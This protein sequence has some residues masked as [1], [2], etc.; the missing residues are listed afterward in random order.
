M[1]EASLNVK[2]R[3]KAGKQFSKRLRR[4][5]LIPGVLYGLGMDPMPL[6]IDMKELLS[7][8]HSAGRN[9]V[10]NLAIEDSKKKF[11][12]F[13]YD[14]QHDPISGEIIHIDMKQ[15]SLNEKINVTIPIRL[16]G[17]SIG[18]KTEDGIVEHIM[19]TLDIICLPSDI[20]EEITVDISDLQI[21]DGIHVR[22]LKHENFDILSDGENVAVHIIAPRVVVVAE[23]E[24][25]AE[26]EEEELTEPEV[27]GE[28][29]REEEK[30][31]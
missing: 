12:S 7:L 9:V 23:A 24:E 27:I 30:E 5:K 25:V 4:E 13:I 8:L 26:E 16:V 1:T 11:K 28:E 18:V 14:I 19:H 15:I 10:V 6:I 21:G 3:E 22:D 2:I 31:K 17:T 29:T 20:P